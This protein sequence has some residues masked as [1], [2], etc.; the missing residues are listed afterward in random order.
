MEIQSNGYKICV[1]GLGQGAKVQ[2]HFERRPKNII[3]TKFK[4]E[5]IFCIQF[6]YHYDLDF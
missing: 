2:S 4:I 6:G 1:G 5:N 3:L